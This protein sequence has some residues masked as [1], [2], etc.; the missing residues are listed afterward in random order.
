MTIVLR[1]KVT[2]ARAKAPG[3]TE[4]ANAPDLSVVCL[5]LGQQRIHTTADQ[6][7][8]RPTLSGGELLE[9]PG[10]FLS[11]LNLSANHDYITL[12]NMLSQHRHAMCCA[13]VPTEYSVRVVVVAVPRQRLLPFSGRM[14]ALFI[15]VL[16]SL[17]ATAPP[18]PTEFLVRTGVRE[19]E[20]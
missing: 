11:E 19:G 18:V 3:C 15:A 5:G 16:S 6:V 17:W 14:T 1:R 4:G 7:G 10:L 9:T 2:N 13:P 20:C 12:D 8:H